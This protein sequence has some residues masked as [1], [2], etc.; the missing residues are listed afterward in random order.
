[1]AAAAGAPSWPG[2]LGLLARPPARAAAAF[3]AAHGRSAPGRRGSARRPEL[4]YRFSSARSRHR[5]VRALLGQGDPADLVLLGRDPGVQRRDLAQRRGRRGPLGRDGLLGGGDLRLPADQLGLRIAQSV[6]ALLCT[7]NTLRCTW[8]PVATSAG[9]V[10]RSA[11]ARL[12]RLVCC[13]YDERTAW[14]PRAASGDL[15]LPGGDVGPGGGQRLLG[16]LQVAAA[17]ASAAR[18]AASWPWVTAYRARTAVSCV[19]ERRTRGGG[20]APSRTRAGRRART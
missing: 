5:G 19:D 18:A 2:P 7:S 11:I 3:S 9:D 1:M 12:S 14:P 16:V 17:T 8:M 6:I 15:L 13:W 4:R 20:A 10:P